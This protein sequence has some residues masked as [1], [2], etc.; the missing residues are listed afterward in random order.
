MR[1]LSASPLAFPPF[2]GA[3]RLLVVVNLAAYFVLAVA[4]LAGNGIYNWLFERGVFYPEYFLHGW[5]WQPFTYSLMQAGIL[6]TLLSL[7]SLWFLSGFLENFHTRNWV[8]G[9][10][11]V[12]V[13]GAALTA[14]VIYLGSAALHASLEPVPLNGC[15]GGIFGMLVAIGVLYGDAEFMLFPLPISIKARYLAIIYALVSLAMLFGQMRLYAF[16]ELGGALCGWIYLRSMPRRGVTF[17]FSEH[18][19]G[20]RNRYYRW[21]RRRAARKFEVYMRSQGRT[22]RFDGQGRSL[23]EDRDDKSRWN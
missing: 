7:L 23:D 15:F 16:A 6:G 18:W 5:L 8:L 11:A 1:R 22:V 19:Y 13:L 21:K 10:Y 12:S 17:L 2:R 14:L 4:G 20:M 9:L 3:T